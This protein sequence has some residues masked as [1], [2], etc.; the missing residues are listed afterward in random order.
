MEDMSV[1]KVFEMLGIKKAS[2]E[3]L[4][5]MSQEE[6]QKYYKEHTWGRGIRDDEPLELNFNQSQIDEDGNLMIYFDDRWLKED[7]E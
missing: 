2:V 1:K 7:Q 4:L 5:M 3:E 6:R